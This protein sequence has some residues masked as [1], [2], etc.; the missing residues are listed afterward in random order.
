MA[1]K[2]ILGLGPG[3]YAFFDPESKIHLTLGCPAITFVGDIPATHAVTK[4]LRSGKL[5]CKTIVEPK[6]T[7]L[8]GVSLG[9]PRQDTSLTI[10]EQP[11]EQ[12]Q[13]I[14]EESHP[15]E[16]TSEEI[17][18]KELDTTRKALPEE[19]RTSNKSSKSNKSTR[20]SK[21]KSK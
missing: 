2:R 10:K 11:K 9:Q 14:A 19:E 16:K 20:K 6:A 21:G 18:A 12:E 13:V 8:D 7:R 5:V 17:P 15:V 1:E 4:A 3:F